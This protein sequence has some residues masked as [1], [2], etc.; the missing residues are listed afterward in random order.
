MVRCTM[1]P[2][3]MYIHILNAAEPPDILSKI[4]NNISVLGTLDVLYWVLSTNINGAL[5]H[6]TFVDVYTYLECGRAA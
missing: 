1:Q 5:H 4:S 3:L 6:A 2:L